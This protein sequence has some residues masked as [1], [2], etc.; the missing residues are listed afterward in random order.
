M[1]KRLA[2]IGL[3]AVFVLCLGGYFYSGI[4]AN[5]K[6]ECG[7]NA[8]GE[9]NCSF[10]NTGWSPSTICVTVDVVNESAERASSG[11]VCS[12]RVW[13]NDTINRDI[14]VA[15]PYGHCHVPLGAQPK[16]VCSVEVLTDEQRKYHQKLAKEMSDSMS[17]V[18]DE[19]FMDDVC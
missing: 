16:K 4:G 1:S 2:K 6:V 9:G 14:V 10:T 7:V 3:G 17:P 8:L 12:G 19:L 11:T 5:I 15:M 13:P 18:A